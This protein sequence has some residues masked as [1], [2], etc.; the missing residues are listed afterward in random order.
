MTISMRWWGKEGEILSMKFCL[1]SQPKKGRDE[2]HKLAFSWGQRG[3]SVTVAF[4]R[5]TYK[6]ERGIKVFIQGGA[7]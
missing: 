5:E 3:Q 1:A 6:G 7:V 2:G 4:G